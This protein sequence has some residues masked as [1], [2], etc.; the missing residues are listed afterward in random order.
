M[1]R[2]SWLADY[3]D[4]ENF[5]GLF[6]SENFCPGGPNYT[7]F[8]NS[9]FDQ[10]FQQAKNTNDPFERDQI[11]TQL[12]SI[13]MAESPVIPLFYDQVTHFVSN[14]VIELETNPVNML[15]LKTARKE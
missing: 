12:D 10:L 6:Y 13:V 3:P 4:A 2:K 14:K 8:S 1:F 9:E 11:Y 15:N 5:L 7:H